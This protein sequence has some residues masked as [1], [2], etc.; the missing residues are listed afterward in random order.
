MDKLV[1]DN[2]NT[3]DYN[4]FKALIEDLLSQFFLKYEYILN[5]E[6]AIKENEKETINSNCIDKYIRKYNISSISNNTSNIIDINNKTKFELL[7]LK[8]YTQESSQLCGYHALF[9]ALNYIK[10]T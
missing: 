3:D 1:K 8:N 6:K 7:L 4:Y 5:K 9:N 2:T 10:N